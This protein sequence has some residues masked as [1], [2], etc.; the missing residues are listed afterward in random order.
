MVPMRPRLRKFFLTA[1][2]SSS[3][4]WLGAVLV[5]LALATASLT[6][7]DAEVAHAGYLLLYRVAYVVIVP[8][9]LAALVSG[10][11]QSLGT[12]WGVF[13]HYW[14]LVK[15]LL[16]AVAVTVLL[17]HLPTVARMSRLA[18]TTFS[19]SD[20]ET[21]RLQLIVHAVGG[22]LVLLAATALSFYKPWGRTNYGRRTLAK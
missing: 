14:I 13:R 17:L 4:G 7:A 20:F 12:E 9:S 16:S 8:L 3:V 15:F 21:L 22:L 18:Q 19:T 2:V 6:S 11:V 5:Y 1:H 10:L